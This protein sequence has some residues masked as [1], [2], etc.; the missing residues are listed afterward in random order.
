MPLKGGMDRS[1]SPDPSLH[2]PDRRERISAR[3]DTDQ[4]LREAHRL[5][6]SLYVEWRL[7]KEASGF[8]W[9]NQGIPTVPDNVWRTY[10]KVR[11]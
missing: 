6:G 2:R 10:Q 11:G 3:H 9:D 1:T 4:G 8:G 7:L 5:Q